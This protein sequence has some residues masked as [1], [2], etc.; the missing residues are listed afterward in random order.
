MVEVVV[1]GDLERERWRFILVDSHARPRLRCNYFGRERRASKRHKWVA[2]ESFDPDTRG[3][4]IARADVPLP[5]AV[6]LE[7]RNRLCDLIDVSVL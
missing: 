1:G 3:R 6:A 7:A 4:G 5:T 2:T